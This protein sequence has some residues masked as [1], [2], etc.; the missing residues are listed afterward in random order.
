MLIKI[1]AKVVR[2]GRYITFKMAEVA[3]PRTLFAV[4]PCL[5][6]DLRYR[7][8]QHDGGDKISEAKLFTE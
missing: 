4:I 6:A 8:S 2:H 5:I 3:M 1:G 7:P